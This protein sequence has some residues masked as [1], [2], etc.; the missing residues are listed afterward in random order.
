MNKKVIIGVVIAIIGLVFCFFYINQVMC[1]K[2]MNP[3][4]TYLRCFLDN[5]RSTIS[6]LIS[7]VV[8]AIGVDIMTKGGEE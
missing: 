6:G 4:F 2:L 5:P 1:Y 7:L 8:V 3:G